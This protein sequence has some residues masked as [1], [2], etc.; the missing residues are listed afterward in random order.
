[1]SKHAKT[2][3]IIDQAREILAEGYPMTLRQVFYQLV[4][5]L[6]IKNTQ[7]EYNGLS[8]NLVYARQEGIIPWDWIEDRLRIPRK[9]SMWHNLAAF[10]KTAERA[11]RRNV[12][13]TQPEYLEFWLEKDALSGIFEAELRPYGVTLNVG[14]GYD[15]WA[16]LKHAAERYAEAGVE[17][18]VLYFG[19]FDPSGEDM[20]RSLLDRLGTLGEPPQFIKCA[21]TKQDVR[22]YNLPPQMVKRSDTRAAG[23]IAE[24]GEGCVELDALPVDVLRERIREEVGRRMDLTALAQVREIE[25]KDRTRLVAALTDLA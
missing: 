22:E 17:V 4:S 14:R 6:A 8:R 13:E 21:L 2:L 9:V 19:D 25:A 7:G 24:H 20:A 12:W 23:F 5:R 3:A 10:A 18:T 1:M 16:S 11:Y 15:G